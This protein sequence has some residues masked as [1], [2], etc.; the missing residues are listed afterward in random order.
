MESLKKLIEQRKTTN[1]YKPEPEAPTRTTR[2]IDSPLEKRVG[3][4]TGTIHKAMLVDK[5]NLPTC[6]Q[7]KAQRYESRSRMTQSPL[8]TAANPQRGV[9]QTAA[10]GTV[11]MEEIQGRIPDPVAGG[12]AR[13][14]EDALSQIQSGQPP[15]K[16]G[17]PRGRSGSSEVFRITVG[18][19]TVAPKSVSKPGISHTVVD[20][21]WQNQ[22]EIGL[23]NV[24]R[25]Q[26]EGRD[27]V[28][29]SFMYTEFVQ[30]DRGKKADGHQLV[31]QQLK[32]WV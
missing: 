25:L 28:T 21:K 31:K 27:K 13:T 19:L 5:R 6:G 17:N 2:I 7:I 26:V 4:S 22:D 18:Q 11:R 15:A 16:I 24:I 14:E 1:P 10:G 20:S 30:L 32:K 12:V 23:G 9:D 8:Q 3:A 29:P